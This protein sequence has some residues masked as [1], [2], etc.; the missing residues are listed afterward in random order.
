MLLCSVCISTLEAIFSYL[1][2]F[3]YSLFLF[4]VLYYSA[5]GSLLTNF[6]YGGSGSRFD[7]NAPAAASSLEAATGE[8]RSGGKEKEEKRRDIVRKEGMKEGKKERK[9]DRRRGEI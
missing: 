4:C 7:P 8:K 2:L 3:Y 5:V 1:L 6:H 9:K